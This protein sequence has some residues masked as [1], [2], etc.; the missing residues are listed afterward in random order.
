MDWNDHSWWVTKV[1]HVEIMKELF[2]CD[3]I[4]F[5]KNMH[6]HKFANVESSTISPIHQTFE[7]LKKITSL[8]C[9]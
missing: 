8:Q 6:A 2:A 3:K 7:N 5:Y 4:E 1:V 9:Y